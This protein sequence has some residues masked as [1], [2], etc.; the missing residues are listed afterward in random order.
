MNTTLL[1]LF[2]IFL[3]LVSSRLVSAF[4][5][6]TTTSR[7]V[8]AVCP[9]AA[10]GNTCLLHA[11]TTSA[12]SVDNVIVLKDANA[13]GDAVRKIVGEAAK[14]AV[15]E[16]GYFALAIPGGSILKMLVGEDI[17]GNW[18]SK[19]T[20]AYVNHKCVDMD[21]GDLATHAKA[22]KL[23]LDKWTD[24]NTIIMD[25]TGQGEAEAE[26]YEAKLKSLSSDILPCD[27]ESGLPVFDL[28]LIGVGDD[29]HVGSL[30]PN[31]DEVL[32]G[33]DGPWVLPVAMKSPPSITLSLPVMANAKKVVVA[34]CG[35]SDKY[36]QGKSDGMRRAVAAEDETLQTFPAVGLRS[37]ATWIMDEAAASKLGKAYNQ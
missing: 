1:Y 13:V 3:V 10:R 18:T 36:P 22:R 31:R 11:G 2:A 33:S 6:T 4:T 12:T 21:D 34:A 32:V 28:A 26:S 27:H 23:F 16:R 17:L 8:F 29:G 30:Y 14:K 24:V 7:P 9:N 37:V 25:G 15:D 20:I 19:T 35:V 5:T